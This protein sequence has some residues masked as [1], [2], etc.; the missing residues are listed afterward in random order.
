MRARDLQREATFAIGDSREDL[1]TAA[2]VGTFWL[3]A[4]A[5]ENDP[6]LREAL[7]AYGNVRIAEAAHGG[8]VYEA[9]ITTLAERR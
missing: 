8:G 4:N 6:T 3:V 9:V 2:H 5:L 1:A 7:G